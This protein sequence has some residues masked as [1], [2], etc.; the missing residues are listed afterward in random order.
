MDHELNEDFEFEQIDLEEKRTHF[1]SD[2]AIYHYYILRMHERLGFKYSVKI[3]HDILYK[4]GLDIVEFYSKT[5][6]GLFY[7][8]RFPSVKCLFNSNGIYNLESLVLNYYD[9]MLIKAFA[10]PNN[11]FRIDGEFKY[12]LEDNGVCDEIVHVPTVLEKIEYSVDGKKYPVVHCHSIR[13]INYLEEC[14]EYLE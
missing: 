2:A 6:D 1:R 5:F 8:Y 13:R 7:D 4:S 3:E 12:V 10:N 11:I 9:E 14:I